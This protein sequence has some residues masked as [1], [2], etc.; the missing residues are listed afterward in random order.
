MQNALVF[1]NGMCLSHKA[2]VVIKDFS[3]VSEV[4]ASDT[5]DLAI[6]Q[7]CYVVRQTFHFDSEN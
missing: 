1:I 4:G 5:I 6:L 2:I 7:T 3:I